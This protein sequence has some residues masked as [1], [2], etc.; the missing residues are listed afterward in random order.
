MLWFK[1]LEFPLSPTK[2]NRPTPIGRDFNLEAEV[3]SWL[4]RAGVTRASAPVRVVWSSRLRSAAGRADFRQRVIALNPRLREHGP[5]EIDRT[6]RHEA[7]HLLAHFRA[8]RRRISP[9]GPEWRTACADLG[10]PGEPRC[11][12]MPF[13]VARRA[14]PWLY[15]CP[16]CATEFSR[17]RVLRRKVACL[18]CCRRHNR[19]QFDPRFGLILVSGTKLRSFHAVHVKCV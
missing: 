19:G 7:A 11:H 1:Q 17:A 10:I 18:A 9:H 2:R 5:A 3:Y 12:T 4:A 15:R 14:R 13:P 16:H 6:L 8:G